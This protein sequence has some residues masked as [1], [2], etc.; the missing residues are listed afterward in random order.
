MHIMC[1]V[2]K[3]NPAKIRIAENNYL[4]HFSL[5]TFIFRDSNSKHHVTRPLFLY[6]E[7]SY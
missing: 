5:S 7:P 4:F 3:D 2:G 1:V 6:I